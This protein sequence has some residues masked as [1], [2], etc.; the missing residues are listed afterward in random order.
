VDHCRLT[1]LVS[2][3]GAG[4]AAA[5]RARREGC[6]AFAMGALILPSADA[7]T[8]PGVHCLGSIDGGLCVT[9]VP[10]CAR[11][12]GRGVEG[13]REHKKVGVDAND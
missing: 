13:G 1:L 2:E 4:D 8:Q 10:T 3:G 6:V 7:S 5:P 12:G 11:A 9:R